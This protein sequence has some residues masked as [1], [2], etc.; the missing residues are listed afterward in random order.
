[1]NIFK[2][3]KEVFERRKALNEIYDDL[4][5][6]DEVLLEK[7]LE[8]FNEL[9]TPQFAEIGLAN[10]N[11]KYLWFS[12]YNE[13]GIRHVIEY[14]VFRYFGGSFTYGN[15]YNFVPVFNNKNKLSYCKTDK[16]T[17]VMY[18]KRFKGWQKSYETES[19]I[20]VDKISTVNEEKLR[21]SINLVLENNLSYLNEWFNKTKT[22]DENIAALKFDYENPPFEYSHVKRRISV[23]YLLSFLYDKKGEKDLSV[24]HLLKHFEENLIQEDNDIQIET[25]KNKFDFFKNV[26]I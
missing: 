9:I 22:L 25:L 6:L 5:N 23:N 17:K 15:C 24:K 12:D 8:I 26:E 3:I 20:N 18:Y 7:R 14:N 13:D 10:W 11:G 21:K 19:Q 2:K 1:M 4:N 16:S